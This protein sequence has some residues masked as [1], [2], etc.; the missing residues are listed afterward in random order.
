VTTRTEWS[1]TCC[2][3]PSRRSSSTS[4]PTMTSS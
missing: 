1:S 2:R 3:S 4:S